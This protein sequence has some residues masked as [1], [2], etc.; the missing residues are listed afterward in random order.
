[1]NVDVCLILCAGLGTRMGEIGKVLPKV[2]WPIFEKSILELQIDYAR[3]LGCEKIYINIHHKAKVVINSLTNNYKKNITFLYE[4]NLLGSGGAIHNLAQQKEINYNGN[5]L[6][7]NGDQFFFIQKF[8]IKNAL[9]KI[10]GCSAVLFGLEVSQGSGYNETVI[11]NERLVSIDKNTIDK[12]YYTFSGTAL[13]NLNS[14]EKVKGE[15]NFFETVADFHKKSVT[16]ISDKNV[17]YWDFGTLNRYKDSMFKVL[18]MLTN[19]EK[20]LFLEF[21]T[22]NKAISIHDV[23][24]NSYKSEHEQVIDIDGSNIV[25]ASNVIIFNKSID[26]I[27]LDNSII[28]NGIREKV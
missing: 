16:I 12:K 11:Q 13:I 27:R 5:L 14:L 26:I 24:R 17:E 2:I 10:G 8:H 19:T 4:E 21:L 6:T 1:M 9:E 15:S 18:R 23:K 20:S 22:K 7:I 28:Y 3:S 25:E